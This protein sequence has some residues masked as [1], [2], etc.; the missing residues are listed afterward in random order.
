MDECGQTTGWTGYG[1]WISQKLNLLPLPRVNARSLHPSLT[2]FFP[3]SVIFF[4]LLIDELAVTECQ[5][6]KGNVIVVVATSFRKL[7]SLSPDEFTD[8]RKEG[9]REGRKEII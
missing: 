9:G 3:L 7:S 4:P 6:A 2:P 1:L 8:G 5:K